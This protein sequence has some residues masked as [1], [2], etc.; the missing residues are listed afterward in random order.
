VGASVTQCDISSWCPLHKPGYHCELMGRPQ[1][2]P[3]MVLRLF[4]NASGCRKLKG[5]EYKYPSSFQL[6][7]H[8]ILSRE[9]KTISINAFLSIYIISTHFK[10]LSSSSQHQAN[11][12]RFNV[13]AVAESK[14]SEKDE[15]PISS[16]IFAKSKNFKP[17]I[18]VN[19]AY[20]WITC[21]KANICEVRW[22]S[23]L[24]SRFN[25]VIELRS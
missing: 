19:Q 18:Y 15:K 13:P 6:S 4:F 20:K 9:S 24:L 1:C 12:N 17:G 8:G 14:G 21:Y 10:R 25:Y 11:T 5:C 16:A 22:L 23:T 3:D 2:I 7:D